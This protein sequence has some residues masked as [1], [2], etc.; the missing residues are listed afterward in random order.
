MKENSNED[1]NHLSGAEPSCE[2]RQ[3]GEDIFHGGEDEGAWA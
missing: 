2:S 1:I 3:R